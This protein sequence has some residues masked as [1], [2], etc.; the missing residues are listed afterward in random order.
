MFALCAIQ[1]L[2]ATEKKSLV[3][4]ECVMPLAALPTEHFPSKTIFG[5]TNFRLHG[6]L[7]LDLPRLKPGK[8]V[9][10]GYWHQAEIHTA[11]CC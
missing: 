6:T 3:G 2:N 10:T 11:V 4:I 9:S 1:T 5:Y 7:A 8:P